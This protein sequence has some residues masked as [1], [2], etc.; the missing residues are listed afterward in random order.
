MTACMGGNC[1]ERE[2][3]SNYH[4]ADRRLPSE[5]LCR[6]GQDGR[7]DIAHVVLNKPPE[8]QVRNT[9]PSML[10]SDRVEVAA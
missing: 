9:L 5:R 4:A 10:R 7:S 6:R 2:R 8:S 1:H 3:C